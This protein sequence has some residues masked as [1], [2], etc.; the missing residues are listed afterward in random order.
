MASGDKA[1]PRPKTR[2]KYPAG[3][4]PQRI[5]APAPLALFGWFV[6]VHP[7]PIRKPAPPALHTVSKNI[8][9]ILHIFYIILLQ[10]LCFCDKL[11][12]G[13]SGNATPPR[14]PGK[15]QNMAIYFK[16]TKAEALT[17]LHR[18]IAEKQALA[19]A[20]SIA[21]LEKTKTGSEFARLGSGLKNCNLGKYY[22][23]EDAAHPYITVTTQ[24]TPTPGTSK[25]ISD[26]IPIYYYL[27]EL[28]DTDPRKADYKRQ[29]FRQTVT[30][31]P[32]EIRQALINRYNHFIAGIEDL[33]KQVK[34]FDKAFD[35][36]RKAIEAAEQKLLIE[37][38]SPEKTPFKT[39]LYWIVSET[40]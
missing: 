5:P 36:Y 35:H 8:F 22:P 29:F 34:L 38:G 26:E 32:D 27:D 31:S 19:K 37:S 28:P 25:Y 20:W 30:M 17:E 21:T 23:V 16:Y 12:I 1:Y 15:G 33:Q 24:Y 39:S 18:R 40:K 14:L 13:I 3:D 7:Y 10:Y 11:F 2:L 9:E 6:R 4:T